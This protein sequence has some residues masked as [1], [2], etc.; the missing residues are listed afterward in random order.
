[1]GWAFLGS[2]SFYPVDFDL[3]VSK[4]SKSISNYQILKLTLKIYIISGYNRRIVYTL[5]YF[6]NYNV[7]IK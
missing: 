1:M 6:N 5:F 7:Y 4:V 3:L 2:N